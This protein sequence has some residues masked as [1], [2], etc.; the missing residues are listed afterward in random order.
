MQIIYSQFVERGVSFSLQQR[1]G[2]RSYELLVSL[3]DY[4][5]LA[6]WTDVS[7]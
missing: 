2:Q 1:L 4:V 6:L 3:C 7:S 5:W